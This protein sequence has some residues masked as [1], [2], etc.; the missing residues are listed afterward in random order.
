MAASVIGAYHQMSFL[1][2]RTPFPPFSTPGTKQPGTLFLCAGTSGLLLTLLI[3]GEVE[4]LAV[5]F[6]HSHQKNVAECKNANPASS[7]F[8]GWLL[9]KLLHFTAECGRPQPRNQATGSRG[10]SQQD[11]LG[12]PTAWEG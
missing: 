6:L 5:I 12:F 3:V 11:H 7:A 10:S 2:I 8:W 1:P 9:L 4:N